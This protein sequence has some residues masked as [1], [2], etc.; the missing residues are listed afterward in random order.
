M[1]TPERRKRS[2]EVS[3]I[4]AESIERTRVEIVR[5]K[6]YEIQHQNPNMHIANDEKEFIPV[7]DSCDRGSL[8]TE[9]QNTQNTQY[10]PSKTSISSII[11]VIN[12]QQQLENIRDIPQTLKDNSNVAEPYRDE[13]FQDSC[14]IKTGYEAHNTMYNAQET[15]I[16]Y[17]PMHG[18]YKKLKMDGDNVDASNANLDQQRISSGV[19]IRLPNICAILSN[20]SSIVDYSS[21][22]NEPGE[23]GGDVLAKETSMDTPEMQLQQ[24]MQVPAPK[25]SP[26][27]IRL[28][29][30]CGDWT[31]VV[32][33]EVLKSCTIGQIF[34]AYYPDAPQK[35]IFRDVS[36]KVILNP[37]SSIG[38]QVSD[39]QRSLTI[40]ATVP[41][42]I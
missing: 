10:T 38:D 36:S 37:A 6:N 11:S 41:A 7:L 27:S 17:S 19:R 40:S 14:D 31:K 1:F 18:T 35:L 39:N 23:L 26:N 30:L 22:N 33:C 21:S 42:T 2:Q 28:M 16:D 20:K 5:A 34:Y 3:D 32:D 24:V 15:S 13:H 8:S 9:T 12:Q 25:T 29:V 4:S